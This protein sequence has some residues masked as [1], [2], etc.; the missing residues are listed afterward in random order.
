M[1]I[2]NKS[3]EQKEE[4]KKPWNVCE[5]QFEQKLEV[6]STPNDFADATESY[7]LIMRFF[8]H[9]GIIDMPSAGDLLFLYQ[10]F[11]DKYECKVLKPQFQ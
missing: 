1:R 9:S 8:T 10:I 11:K 4:K 2:R 5:P 7:F 6:K 3:Y